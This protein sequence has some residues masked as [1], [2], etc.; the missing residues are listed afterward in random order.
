MINGLFAIM[1][2]IKVY[3][4]VAAMVHK[5]VRWL[6]VKERTNSKLVP[7]L[8]FKYHIMKVLVKFKF[9]VFNVQ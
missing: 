9:C 7:S 5:V 8:P 2:V 4:R 1:I 3:D 6:T